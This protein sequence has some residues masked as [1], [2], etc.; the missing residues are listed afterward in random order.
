MNFDTIS[1]IIIILCFI[2]IIGLY[3][4]INSKDNKNQNNNNS[5]NLRSY[6]CIYYDSESQGTKI[7]DEC[8]VECEEQGE[9]QVINN[10]YVQIGEELAEFYVYGEEGEE[11]TTRSLPVYELQET[12]ITNTFPPCQ[13]FLAQGSFISIE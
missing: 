11:L 13:R 3:F 2:I 6:D 12:I 1:N 10:N 8:I 9:Y 7:R 4:F 5:K